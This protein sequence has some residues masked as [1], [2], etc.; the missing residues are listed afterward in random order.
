LWQNAG[1]MNCDTTPRPTSRPTWLRLIG[2]LIIGIAL[3][4]GVIAAFA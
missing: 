3:V 1:I 4:L 2:T